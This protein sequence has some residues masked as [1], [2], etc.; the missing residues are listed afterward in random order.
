M[1]TCRY[2]DIGID[3]D[4]YYKS[5]VVINTKLDCNRIHDK[6]VVYITSFNKVTYP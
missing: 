4:R 6:R 5:R 1:Y 2:I 3:V